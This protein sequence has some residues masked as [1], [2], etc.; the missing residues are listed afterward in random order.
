MIKQIFYRGI[1]RTKAYLGVA[2]VWSSIWL[3]T[4]L[5]QNGEQGVWYDPSD[6]ST[7]FQDAAM[8]I[9]VTAS[10]DP[11][12]LILDKSG[13]GNHATQ[14]VSASRPTY[15]ADGVLNWIST[16]GVDDYLNIPSLN[17]TNGSFA[18]GHRVNSTTTSSIQA[19]LSRGSGGYITMNAL[20]WGRNNG[21]G[22][23]NSSV[24][25]KSPQS[26]IGNLTGELVE[27]QD[28]KGT[29]GSAV[30]GASSGLSSAIFLFAFSGS[31]VA[32]AKGSWTG[33]VIRETRLT[34]AEKSNIF[35]YLDKKSGVTL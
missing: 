32:P 17:L 13:N 31:L 3:P 20:Y 11:V 4:Q 28:S 1:E 24:G 27:Y 33:I 12:G 9:P 30:G 22:V 14:S 35:N 21:G 2:Q 6:L 7:L 10:G 19:I 5:F 34:G 25:V 8:T 26:I 29:I 16:D 23:N 15:M 18:L